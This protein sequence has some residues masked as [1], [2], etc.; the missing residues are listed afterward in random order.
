MTAREIVYSLPERF[1]PQVAENTEMT[2]HLQL[3]GENGG[4]FTVKVDDG[5]CTVT[6]GLSGEPECVVKTSDKAYED[7]ELG[8]T[9]PQMALMTGKV[10][11]SN[12]TGLLKFIQMFKRLH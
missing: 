1:K 8:R 11:V 6:E 4:D 7:L 3:T 9:N 2:V 12:I 10:K 5:V